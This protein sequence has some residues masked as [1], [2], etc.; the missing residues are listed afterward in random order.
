MTDIY[1]KK[2]LFTALLLFAAAFARAAEPEVFR[3]D[4]HNFSSLTVVDGVPVDYH[5][6]PDSAGWAVFVC[7]PEIAHEICFNNDKEHLT[8]RT[9]AEEKP[10]VGVP[11]V[12]VYSTTLCKVENSGDS[13]VRVLSP[14]PVKTLKARQIGNGTLEIQS[15]DADEVDA[16][17][18]A[19]NGTLAL[20]GK[21]GKVKINNVSSGPVSARG[22]HAANISCFVFGSGNIE[23]APSE[24]LK[25]YGAGTGKVLYHGAPKVSRRGIG[26][27]VMPANQHD[28]VYI[29]NKKR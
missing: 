4:V 26:V 15:I 28:A 23:C 20:N 13:L 16:A 2:I 8:I 10:I 18:T 12:N 21:A 19:G 24:T 1:M 17:V 5:A 3:I 29:D 6:L 11:R 27:K 7:P 22:L 9:T 25:V 14:G